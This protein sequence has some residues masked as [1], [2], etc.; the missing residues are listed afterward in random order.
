MHYN[1][2]DGYDKMNDRDFPDPAHDRLV[3]IKRRNERKL[4]EEVLQTDASF[5]FAADG[6]GTSYADF[7]EHAALLDYA[8]K[9]GIWKLAEDTA[10]YIKDVSPY[11]TD[12]RCA[13]ILNELLIQLPATYRCAASIEVEDC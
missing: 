5:P 12:R 10:G 3:G 7:L 9:G 1:R 8:L 11:K 2:V 13:I 4:K 6:N